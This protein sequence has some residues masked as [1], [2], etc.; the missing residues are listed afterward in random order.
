MVELTGLGLE[1]H[2]EPV[3]A[4]GSDFPAQSRL[5]RGNLYNALMRLSA[6][7]LLFCAGCGQAG[8][9]CRG[10]LCGVSAPA[11][12]IKTTDARGG[13]VSAEVKITNLAVPPGVTNAIAYCAIGSGSTTCVINAFAA[14]H[15]ELDIG[16]AG[17][18]TEH[19]RI[20]VSRPMGPP[21]CCGAS[22]VPVQR[23][24]SLAPTP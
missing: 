19:L 7:V 11:V 4:G 24:V 20:D 16:A 9:D 14:G 5:R 21:T 13:A 2:L 22:F 1:I 18:T 8:L 15:Y 6:L 12:T 23:D 10:V 17:Y 3:Q